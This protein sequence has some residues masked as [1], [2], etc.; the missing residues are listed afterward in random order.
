M[1]YEPGPAP[2]TVFRGSRRACD[3][4]CLVLEATALPYELAEEGGAWQL[5]VAPEVAPRACEELERYRVERASLAEQQRARSGLR[6]RRPFGGVAAGAI[7]LSLIH[8]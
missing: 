5:N 2:V 7:G 1:L 6:A 3:E 4:L 8:I